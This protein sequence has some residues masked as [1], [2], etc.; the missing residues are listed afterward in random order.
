MALYYDVLLLLFAQAAFRWLVHAPC[1]V[2]LAPMVSVLAHLLALFVSIVGLGGHLL[3]CFVLLLLGLVASFLLVLYFLIV[4]FS[5]SLALVF[6]LYI[7]SA[8]FVELELS[9]EG[10]ECSNMT[11]IFLLSGDLAPHVPLVFR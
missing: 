4:T 5:L 7:I 1:H 10:I 11:I 2:M 9:L 6:P 8:L 3:P